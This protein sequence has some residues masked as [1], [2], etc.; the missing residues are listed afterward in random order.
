[1]ATKK[2]TLTYRCEEDG[3]EQV[4]EITAVGNFDSGHG[5]LDITAE[6][7]PPA[8]DDTSDPTGLLNA[9]LQA[10]K[11]LCESARA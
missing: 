2:A 1:M 6:F 11:N 9:A 8:C 3:H 10:W 7:D 4:F 5:T